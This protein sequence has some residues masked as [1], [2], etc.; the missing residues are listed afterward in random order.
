VTRGYD[1]SMNRSMVDIP[2]EKNCSYNTK[3]DTNNETHVPL[4]TGCNTGVTKI[5][6]YEQVKTLAEVIDRLKKNM[7]VIMSAKLTPNFYINEGMVLLE[8]PSMK[9]VKM[10][11][12]AMGHAFLAMGIMELPESLHAKEGKYCLVVSNSWGAGWGA[13]GYSCIT[14]NWL[15]KYRLNSSFVAVNSVSI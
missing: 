6:K 13:G 14:E 15:T 12:H 11:N 8:D 2:L 1:Y 10:D 5:T 7:P 9:D 3:I 4:Q